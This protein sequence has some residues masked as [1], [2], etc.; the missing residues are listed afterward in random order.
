MILKKHIK[1]FIPVVF[2]HL[3]VYVSAQDLRKEVYVVK[4]YEPSLSEAS[5]INYLPQ[6]TDT[7]YYKPSI[8]YDISPSLLEIPF[9]LKPIKPAKMVGTT[10]DKLY[11]H[12][13][14]AG[15]GNYFTPVLSYKYNNLRSKD[16]AVGAAFDYKSSPDKMKLENGDKS[17]AGYSKTQLGIYGKKFYD[18]IVM[19]GDMSANIRGLHY[20]GYNTAIFPDTALP[21]IK[22]KDIKQRFFNFKVNTGIYSNYVDSSRLHYK[23]DLHHN[24]VQ[25]KYDFKENEIGIEG[26]FYKQFSKYRVHLNTGFIH[27]NTA[28][29]IDSIGESVFILH[30][31]TRFNQENLAIRFGLNMIFHHMEETKA[32]FY[33]DLKLTLNVLDNILIPY[34]GVGG[35]FE[36]VT[37]SRLSYQNPFIIPGTKAG[38][39]DNKINVYGGLA[40]KVSERIDYNA[41]LSYD[42]KNN[43]NFFVNDTSSEL[44]HQ[45]TTIHDDVEILTFHSD[46]SVDITKDFKVNSGINFYTYTTTNYSFAYHKPNYDF[47]VST[48]YNIK[49]KIIVNLELS[50]IGERYV[51]TCT[52]TLLYATKLKP[53]I[54]LNFGMEYKYSNVISAYLNFYN[55]VSKEYY[56]WNQYPTQKLFILF[57]LSYRF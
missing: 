40:G 27:Y 38:N 9:D 5:K 21:D 44:Q 17:P 10:I 19:S 48:S 32:Y 42:I 16:F 24:Y 51:N 13:A 3:A 29:T 14:L 41:C 31:Y 34:L 28:N 30:P 2:I 15:L 56:I 20:Y 33:P 12:F 7:T 46:V 52:D 8:N 6:L 39:V 25:D 1:Y 57:A 54:D 53:F 11:N 49:D 43:Y 18:D 55:L 26:A 47:F 23:V 22:G 45:F 36:K 4:P 37:Y 50:G 35:G